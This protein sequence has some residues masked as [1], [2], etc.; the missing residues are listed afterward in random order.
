MQTVLLATMYDALG[1]L[2]VEM[3]ETRVVET[4]IGAAVAVIVSSLVLPTR[5]RSRVLSSMSDVIRTAS[6][7][8]NAI[9][10]P[11]SAG[12][13][14]T[15]RHEVSTL[16]NELNDQLFEMQS[17][18]GP[19]RHHPGSLNQSSIEA[20]MMSLWAVLYNER[21]AAANVVHVDGAVVAPREWERLR[22]AT[23]GNF[24][25]AQSVIGDRVPTRL[26]EGGE[27]V[28]D[29]GPDAADAVRSFL[30]QVARLN[31]ATLD[32]VEAVKPGT[33]ERGP[34]A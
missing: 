15:P 1:T 19:L 8:A 20:Q 34:Q 31:H 5:T 29:P 18:A 13:P 7:L 26:H 11:L 25:A 12:S 22:S 24:A 6:E 23:E 16:V 17:L 9:L 4:T 28:I 14:A 32:F 10:Q 30:T 3:M 27:F 33:V 2:N 21:R